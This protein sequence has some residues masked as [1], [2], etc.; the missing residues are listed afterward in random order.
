ME[1]QIAGW[2]PV[3]CKTIFTALRAALIL[4]GRQASGPYALWRHR[5]TFEEAEDARSS[6]T[7]W[8]MR[9]PW[10]SWED[11]RI[12]CRAALR[13]FS[14]SAAALPPVL[15]GDSSLYAFSPVLL[16]DGNLHPCPDSLPVRQFVD[17]NF[18]FTSRSSPSI[19]TAQRRHLEGERADGASS[20]LDVRACR[21]TFSQVLYLRSGV[22]HHQKAH[23]RLL[24]LILRQPKA[25][26]FDLPSTGLFLALPQWSARQEDSPGSTPPLCALAEGSFLCT[27]R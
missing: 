11:W 20:A 8:N 27:P 25:D 24:G 21:L 22:V 18:V 13:G 9:C 16:R 14:N 23:L 4:R 15:G 7:A 10:D 5:H 12:R 19:R 1:Y 26:D 3:S 17:F 2:L 6:R